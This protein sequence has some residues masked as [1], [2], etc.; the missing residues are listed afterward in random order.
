MAYPLGIQ[1]YHPDIGNMIV[2]E[3][4]MTVSQDGRL[5]R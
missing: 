5:L 4:K 2:R 1:C 3:N